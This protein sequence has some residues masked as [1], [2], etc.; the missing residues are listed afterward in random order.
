M[1]NKDL[2]E[3][4]KQYVQ[5][6]RKKG[7]IVEQLGPGMLLFRPSHKDRV[8]DALEGFN[9]AH[10]GRRRRPGARKR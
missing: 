5:D 4:D 7:V 8:L 10:R 3:A 9:D 2:K 6:L 1:S